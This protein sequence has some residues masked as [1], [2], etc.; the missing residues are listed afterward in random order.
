[1][2]AKTQPHKNQDGDDIITNTRAIP[3]VP[4][5][6]LS[7]NQGTVPTFT[8]KAWLLKINNIRD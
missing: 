8:Q 5:S 7:V 1:M 4:P 3:F 6:D 2:G